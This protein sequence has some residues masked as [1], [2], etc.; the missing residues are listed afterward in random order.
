MKHKSTI[1]PIRQ[2]LWMIAYP[3]YFCILV[4][5]DVMFR[6][7]YRTADSFAWSNLTPLLFTVGWALVMTGLAAILPRRLSQ[8]WII[9]TCALFAVLTLVHAVMFN[10]FGSFFSLQDLVYA[11]DG[12][13][14]FSLSYLNMRKALVLTAVLAI[15]GSICAAWLI[16]KTPWKPR[17]LFAL[18]PMVA[19]AALI[20]HLHTPLIYVAPE[21]GAATMTWDVS[22]EAGEE[23]DP[24]QLLYTEFTNTNK[25]LNMTGLYHYTVRNIVVTLTPS[26]ADEQR[27]ILALDAWHKENEV[28]L[29][30]Y[31]GV[32]EGKNLIMV[33]LES[34]D[35]FL[36]TE[37]YMP[38]LY[39]LQQQSVDFTNNYTPLYLTAGTFGTEFL[40]VTGMIPPQNGASTDV[41]AE[42]AFPYSLP[43]LFRSEGYQANSFHSASRAIYNRGTI[44]ENLGFEHYF[45][46]ADLGMEDYQRDSQLILGFDRMVSDQPFYS[47]IITYSG[48]GPYDESLSNIS[49][50]HLEAAQT[51]V[52]ASGVTGSEDN[53]QE[54]T[55]AVAHAMETDAFIGEL[56]AAL[57]E[58]GHWE[59]TALVFYADHY[60]KYMTDVDF[61]LELKGVPN[62]NLLCETPFFICAS[63]L[64]P[65]TVERLTSSVDIYPT[66]CSLFG[67]DVD[68]S[69]FMGSDALAEGDGYVYWRD[70]SWYD[71]ERYVDGGTIPEDEY[72]AEISAMV[73]RK[74]NLAWNAII[75]DYFA[76]VEGT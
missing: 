31:A 71:G 57:K 73:R 42:N 46:Y 59:D 76:P 53:M 4:G 63:E 10:M 70:Y 26:F 50:P 58:S 27:A 21:T 54:Y 36:L 19:G 52:A 55:L 25:C 17:R 56:V 48:H 69:Y 41:Y 15:A 13:K 8:I 30:D 65:Q 18:I 22:Y 23:V 37:E 29:S 72:G 12:A 20:L 6:Y 68:L 49:D 3:L 74:L 67:L 11:G 1:E 60:C 61:L 5:L 47:F 2:R 51:A 16:S 66:I 14:F 33:M 38:N 35:T 43:N 32:L 24:E 28:S 7:L 34:I 75:Y 9:F 40:S 45:N 62:R 64:E 39:A 44:H